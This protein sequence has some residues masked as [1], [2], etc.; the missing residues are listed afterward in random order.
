M[1]RTGFAQNEAGFSLIELLVV[2]LIIG[3]LAAVALPLFLNQKDKANDAEAKETAHSAQ[4]AM[5]TCANEN[6][7]SYDE[8]NCD[9][10]GLRAIEPSLPGGEE[11]PVDPAPE[12]AGYSIDVTSEATDNVFSIVRDPSGDLSF[13]CTVTGTNQGGCVL[14]GEKVGTWGS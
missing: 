3:I 10:A 8:A 13:P 7:G 11:S 6:D 14:T 2:M 9:L 1:E 5:E 4:V 12:G